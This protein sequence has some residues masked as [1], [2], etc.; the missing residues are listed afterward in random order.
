MC[1]FR[2]S[3]FIQ[4]AISS[5]NLFSHT[6]ITGSPFEMHVAAGS[7]NS[8]QPEEAG[9]STVLTAGIL[10]WNAV[11]VYIGTKLK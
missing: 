6:H 4:Q 5:S 9:W 7:A 3:S 8:M 1:C 2:A 11:L 10:A